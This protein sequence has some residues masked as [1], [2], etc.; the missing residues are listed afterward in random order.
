MLPRD[1]RGRPFE[2]QRAIVAVRNR[3]SG[4]E[5]ERLTQGQTS[6]IQIPALISKCGGFYPR[7]RDMPGSGT[8][9]YE[10]A[11]EIFREHHGPMRTS[12]ALRAGV[13]PRV[14]YALRNA[15][16]LMPVSRGLYRLAELPPLGNPDLATVGAR[17]Y[18]RASS[19]S[20]RPLPITASAR[21]YRMPSVALPRNAER[22]RL[23]YPPLR[24]VW[25][26]GSAF[27]YGVEVHE[28]DDVRVRIYS[29]PKAV[30][31]C[32]KYRYR[33]GL[34]VAIEAL[35]LPRD[36][37]VFDP[38]EIL[39]CARVCRVETVMRPYLEALL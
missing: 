22:P 4:N 6:W 3:A 28:I 19:A 35:R 13:H 7:G 10:R 2:D 31:D 36:S 38:N 27:S 14:L 39:A 24:V 16:V 11:Q 8:S 33:L 34:A 15:G 9:A 25:F 20:F 1:G 5:Q 30:A 32:F 18:L 37:A 29:A 17:A 21:R 12:E 23:E 26:S